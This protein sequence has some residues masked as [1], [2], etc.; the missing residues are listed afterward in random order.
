MADL[1]RWPLLAAGLAVLGVDLALLGD[2][3][4][5]LALALLLG[6]GA[7]MVGAGIANVL[8]HPPE[9]ADESDERDRFG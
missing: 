6:V 9:P 4:R 1:R 3:E 2:G 7:V 5:A 8:R